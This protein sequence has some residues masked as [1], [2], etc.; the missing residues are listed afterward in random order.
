LMV[1]QMPKSSKEER[2]RTALDMHDF[3]VAIMRQNLRRR[4]P[5]ADEQEI[6]AMLIAWLGSRPLLWASGN[7]LQR[8]GGG[9]RS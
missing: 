5:A 7:D 8:P 1:E 2:L 6:E 9:A 3:G 4:H